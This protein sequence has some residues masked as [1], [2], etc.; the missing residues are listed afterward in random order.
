MTHSTNAAKSRGSGKVTFRLNEFVELRCYNT[1]RW[2]TGLVTVSALHGKPIARSKHVLK[3]G[4]GQP[5]IYLS[6]EFSF[7]S[8]CEELTLTT[9]GMLRSRKRTFHPGVYEYTL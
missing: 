8:K 4:N 5:Q 6:S 1:N 7:G 9:I 2:H 3:G